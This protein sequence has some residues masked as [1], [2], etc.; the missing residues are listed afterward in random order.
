MARYFLVVL[1]NGAALYVLFA[2]VAGKGGIID[3]SRRL[4]ELEN[5]ERQKIEK[6]VEV[7]EFRRRIASLRGGEHLDSDLLLMQGRKS[8]NAVI[9]RFAPE[10]ARKPEPSVVEEKAVENRIVWSSA[11]AAILIILGNFLLLLRPG[12]RKE[13]LG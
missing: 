12:G 7:E 2:F 11:A 10:T 4:G 9:F 3:S 1:F 5:L 8:P 6:Q 13:G